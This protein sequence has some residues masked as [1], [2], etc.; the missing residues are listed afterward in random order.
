MVSGQ[1]DPTSTTSKLKRL[2]VVLETDDRS[3]SGVVRGLAYKELFAS[4]DF[5]ANYR[6]RLPK[7]F[8]KLLGNL[9][10]GGSVLRQTGL[11]AILVRLA[12][13]ANEQRIIS[14]ARDSD[15]VYV[16]KVTSLKFIKELCGKTNTPVV[17]DFVDAMWLDHSGFNELLRTVNAVTT[18]NELIANYVKTINSNCTVVPDAPALEKFD[19]R[20]SELASKRTDTIVL[21]WLGSRATAFN[22]YQIWEALEELFPRYP[23]LHLRL[24]GTG[25]DL[26]RIPPFEKVRFSHV[27]WYN[28]DE[29]I[30]EIF[31]MHIGLFP[32]QD[33]ERCRMRGVLKATNYMCGEAAVVTSPVGQCVDVIQDGVNGMIASTTQEWIDKLELLINDAELRQRLTQNG[34]ATV[35][36]HFRLDQ[37]FAKLKHVLETN[38]ASKSMSI[39]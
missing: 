35:R 4:S 9:P 36:A 16:Q 13:K 33:L 2:L 18:D 34:L 32:L 7:R 20:R 37:S 19:K 8:K 22:L 26:K 30:S 5:V 21:G 38:G 12:T 29:M 39:N 3:A 28:E 23:Q 15:V 24:V 14:L 10:L 11:D 17:Y 1:H 25:D 31:G 27:P 6:T